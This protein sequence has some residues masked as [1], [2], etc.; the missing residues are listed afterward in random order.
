[1]DAQDYPR[2]VATDR[3]RLPLGGRLPPSP[4]ASALHDAMARHGVAVHEEEVR[5]DLLSVIVR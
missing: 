4:W 1:M 5:A 3:P 2:N